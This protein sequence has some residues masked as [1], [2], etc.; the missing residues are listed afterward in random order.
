MLVNLPLLHALQ[1]PPFRP[2]YPVPQTQ[3][4]WPGPLWLQSAL[5]S[6]SLVSAE[7]QGKISAHVVPSK[8]NPDEH[9][10]L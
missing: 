5:A 9:A 7:S 10:Q 4:C 3:V 1:Y 8:V 2:L 6:H